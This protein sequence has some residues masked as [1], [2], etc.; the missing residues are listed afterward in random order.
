MYVQE[1]RELAAE[2]GIAAWGRVPALNTNPAF[3]A[4]LADMVLEKLPSAAPRPA[5]LADAQ[6]DAENLNLGPP[7]GMM[8]AGLVIEVQACMSGGGSVLCIY[9]GVVTCFCACGCRK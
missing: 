2:S 5:Y 4:D 1:Y 6:W 9:A 3:I 7:T 8:P